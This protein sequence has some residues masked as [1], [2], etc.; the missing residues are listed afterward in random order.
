[1]ST[2][3]T[4][5]P[6]VMLSMQSAA[7]IFMTLG[8]IC[9]FF[10]GPFSTLMHSLPGGMFTPEVTKPEELG[11][12]YGALVGFFYVYIGAMYFALAASME[13]ARYTVFSRSVLVPGFLGC[14]VLLGKIPWQ[15]LLFAAID[16]L[17]ALW[18]WSV[19]PPAAAGK[20]L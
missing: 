1:M 14:L 19:L 16:V 9:T 15:V 20:R 3:V 8:V 7:G 6:D 2:A 4:T 18:T 10:S 11:G 5:T 17:T 13:F 12:Q